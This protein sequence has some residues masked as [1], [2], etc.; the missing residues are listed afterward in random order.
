[1]DTTLALAA[2]GENMSFFVSKKRSNEDLRAKG[3]KVLSAF[4]TGD[5]FFR[6]QLTPYLAEMVM[7]FSSSIIQTLDETEAHV[8]ALRSLPPVQRALCSA[9]ILDSAGKSLRDGGALGVYFCDLVL[10]AGMKGCNACVQDV[11]DRRDKNRAT[12]L[13]RALDV[14]ARFAGDF[15]RAQAVYLTGHLEYSVLGGP[16]GAFRQTIQKAL[17]LLEQETD[18]AFTQQKAELRDQWWDMFVE[19][20]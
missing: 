9:S 4:S 10:S 17:A 8:G 12:S 2:K 5:A 11:L 18:P 3:V 19:L 20:T 7:G 15:Q 16:E 14:L 6:E 1:L 13:V